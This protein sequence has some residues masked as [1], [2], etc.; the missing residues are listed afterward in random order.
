MRSK[1][2]SKKKASKL[3]GSLIVLPEAGQSRSLVLMPVPEFS[4]RQAS[5]RSSIYGIENQTRFRLTARADDGAIIWRGWFDDRDDADAFLYA[6][7]VEGTIHLQPALWYLPTPMWP[8]L[9]PGLLYDFATVTFITSSPGSNQSYSIPADWSTTN[10]VEIIGGGGA[11]SR[12]GGGGGA[13]AKS[14][15]LT[16]LSGSVT[17][18]VPAAGTGGTAGGDGWFN[19]TAFPASGQKCGAKG[20]GAG[21][22]TGSAST[23]GSSASCYYTGTGSTAYSGGGSPALYNPSGAG[24]SGGGGAGGP[25]GAGADGGQGYDQG[26]GGGGNGGGSAGKASGSGTSPVDSPGGNGGNNSSGSG[27]GAGSTVGNNGGNGSNGGGGG[28]TP[29]TSAVLAGNGGAGQEWDS[30]HG[31]GGGGGGAGYL[32]TPGAAALYGA[33]GGGAAASGGSAADG[34]QGLIVTTYT[35]ATTAF[36]FRLDSFRHILVR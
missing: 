21:G 20:G 31:S 17:V 34:A 11:A 30:T 29:K 9:E 16:G 10:T 1:S 3:P 2:P 25:N 6:M 23:G 4:W 12:T 13:Y 36:P 26:S 14:V 28:G 35:P 33:G 27:G 24:G 19:D 8:N 15:G 5:Q 7:A 22:G 18:R 32:A